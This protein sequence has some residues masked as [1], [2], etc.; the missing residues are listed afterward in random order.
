[1]ARIKAKHM[2]RLP[3]PPVG[4][5]PVPV[6]VGVGVGVTGQALGPGGP[7][8]NGYRTPPSGPAAGTAGATTTAP[9]YDPNTPYPGNQQRYLYNGSPLPGVN[10]GNQVQI[11][12][13]YD[14][15]SLS[16]ELVHSSS[17]HCINIFMFADFSTAAV[18]PSKYA[19]SALDSCSFKSV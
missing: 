13:R 15:D 14:F 11:F 19:P 8:K 2:N 16:N 3:T 17:F 1:M 18:L 7:M 10:Y 5:G 4:V 6:G 9:V 12:V